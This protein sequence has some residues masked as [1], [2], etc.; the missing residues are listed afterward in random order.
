MRD[1]SLG[2]KEG[3]ESEAGAVGTWWAIPCLTDVALVGCPAL[4][5]PKVWDKGQGGLK[6]EEAVAH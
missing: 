3:A 1:G 2:H 6:M 5:G 4:E